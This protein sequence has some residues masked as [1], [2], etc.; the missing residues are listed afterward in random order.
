MRLFYHPESDSLFWDQEWPGPWCEDVTDD[1]RSRAMAKLRGL[2]PGVEVA[3]GQP[4]EPPA[5]HTL[6]RAMTESYR[7]WERKPADLYPTPVDGTESIIP[8]LEVMHE[9]MGLLGN[10]SCRIWEPACGDGRLS[11]VLEHHGFDVLSTDLRPHSGYGNCKHDRATIS[12]GFDFLHDDLA[13]RWGLQYEPDMIVTNPPFSL[14]E[15]F[16][17]KALSYTPN[18]VML[19]KATYWNAASRLPFFEE[20]RPAFVLPLTWRLAFL[21]EERGK[22]PIMDCVWV[23]WS[24]QNQP[25]DPCIFEPIKRRRYP[26]YAKKGLLSVMDIL[27]G[28]IANLTEA[29]RGTPTA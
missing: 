24:Q 10:A 15:A 13:K 5:P 17:R 2:K 11:R 25:G 22:Q 18:V 28:E 9:H 16:I 27:E 14:A 29:L 1:P 12:G 4:P 23:I 7:K 8:A 20:H 6:A 26:G 19:L 3:S 21:E